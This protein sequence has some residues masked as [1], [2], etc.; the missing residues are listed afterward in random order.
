MVSIQAIEHA[1]RIV[2]LAFRG[3]ALIGERVA[4][5]ALPIVQAKCLYALEIQAGTLPGP[6]SEP[7]AT[8][9]A[10]QVLAEVVAALHTEPVPIR[11]SSRR[12]RRVN[13]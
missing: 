10:E 1:G 3:H 9:F 8:R 12:P 4:H 11:L 13:H 5:E 6:Y 7:A 2:A